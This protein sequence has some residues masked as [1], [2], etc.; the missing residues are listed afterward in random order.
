M[1]TKL[2]KLWMLP[3]VVLWMAVAGCGDDGPGGSGTDKNSTDSESGTDDEN[4][5]GDE[6]GTDSEDGTVFVIEAR[7]DDWDNAFPL[8]YVEAQFHKDDDDYYLIA[9]SRFENGAFR[10]EFSSMVDERFLYP[11]M[12]AGAP[13]WL[14]VSNPDAKVREVE[15]FGLNEK[16][17]YRVAILKYTTFDTHDHDF[18]SGSDGYF[19]YADSAVTLIGSTS[20]FDAEYGITA[21]YEYN[22]SLKKGWNVVYQH[23]E[24]EGMTI[25]L[26]LSNKNPG[27]LKWKVK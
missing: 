19:L 14:K 6:N 16:G 15:F 25:K 17:G 24:I 22:V 8:G 20:E 1:N 2:K 18:E 9:G 7:A 5:T 27:G 12:G 23:I 11:I 13:P 3:A 4:G 21:E 26:T 10:L